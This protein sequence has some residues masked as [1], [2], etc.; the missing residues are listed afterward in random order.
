MLDSY[1]K[2]GRAART[3][4]DAARYINRGTKTFIEATDSD[5]DLCDSDQM[6]KPAGVLLLL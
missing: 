2:P 1:T 4:K 3:P 5:N 6:P